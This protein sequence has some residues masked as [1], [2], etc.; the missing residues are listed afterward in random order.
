[1]VTRHG[2]FWSLYYVQAVFSATEMNGFSDFFYYSSYKYALISAAL[3]LPVCFWSVYSALYILF[4]LFKKK[5]YALF[6]LCFFL[7]IIINCLVELIVYLLTRPYTCVNCGTPFE[8][9][10]TVAG[11]GINVAS[12]LGVIALGIKFTKSWYLQQIS[13]RKLAREKISNELKLLKAR[14]QPDF[15]F[16]ILQLIHRKI[17]SDSN[18]AAD[19][20]LK[21]SELLSYTLYECEEDFIAAERV[22]QITKE[23]IT[24]EQT[25]MRT[26]VSA[27]FTYKDISNKYIPSFVVLPLLQLCISIIEKH[28]VKKK[29]ISIDVTVEGDLFKCVFCTRLNN[30]SEIVQQYNNAIERFRE[31]LESLYNDNYTITISETGQRILI[32]LSFLLSDSSIHQKTIKSAYE[33]YEAALV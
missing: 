18:K 28:P 22:I 13:N 7:F 20:L 31:R 8:M 5:K 4:P 6:V 29:L 25:R 1:M 33:V 2:V 24:L 14:I 30:T 17:G 12:F 19:L 15:L 16:K 26:S 10:N 21:L 23:F 3:L 27:E 32:S 11:L 9:V